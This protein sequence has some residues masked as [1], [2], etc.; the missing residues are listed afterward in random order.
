[1]TELAKVIQ[2]LEQQ[3]AVKSARC[4]IADD[5]CANE[6]SLLGTRDGY[7]KLAVAIL[8]LV[9]QADTGQGE[10]QGENFVW[11]DR[12]KQVMYH[13][14]TPSAFLV[15]AYLFD[16]H[17]AY[18]DLLSQFVDPQIGYPLLNDPQ[19]RQPGDPPPPA[20]GS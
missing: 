20:D 14:P 17:Q 15:G 11:D 8:E 16:T 3:I 13:L 4:V 5:G 18:M 6:S 2:F 10:E 9:Q 1:M 19:F 12:V 7:L